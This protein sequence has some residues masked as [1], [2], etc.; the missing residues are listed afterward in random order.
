MMGDGRRAREDHVI[1]GE[2]REFS[3][4]IR[5][6]GD[7]RDFFLVIILSK[8]LLHQVRRRLGEFGWLDHCAVAGGKYARKRRESQVHGEVPRADHAD[9]AFWLELELGARTEQAER[10]FGL[11]PFRPHPFGDMLLREFQCANRTGNVGQGGLVHGAVSE[12][13]AHRFAQGISMRDQQV[14]RLVQPFDPLG[15]RW[16]AIANMR[17]FLAAQ[18]GTHAGSGSAIKGHVSLPLGRFLAEV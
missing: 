18:N 4:D 9:H 10:E 13:L 1:E 3:A 8:Q 2:L 7:N 16:N 6:T 5:T 15:E 11:A 14:D 12:I 17:G